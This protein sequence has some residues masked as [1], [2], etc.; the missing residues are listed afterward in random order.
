MAVLHPMGTCSLLR[1]V[2]RVVTLH[3]ILV[4]RERLQLLTSKERKTPFSLASELL[5]S[6]N[7]ARQWWHIPLIPSTWEAEAGRFLSLRPAWSTE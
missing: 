5:K 2:A 4:D 3:S 6:I 1:R 7:K